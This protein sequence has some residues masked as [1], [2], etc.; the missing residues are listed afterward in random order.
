MHIP[1]KFN[2]HWPSGFREEDWDA[3]DYGRQQTTDSKWWQ[4]LKWLFGPKEQK[5]LDI[6]L[7]QSLGTHTSVRGW[8][9]NLFLKH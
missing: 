7:V 9:V 3:I 6:Y 5:N 4:Y 1:T 2:N 8:K